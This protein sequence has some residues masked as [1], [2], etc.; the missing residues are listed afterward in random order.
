[1]PETW[2]REEK[3]VTKN[4]LSLPWRSPVTDFLQWMLCRHDGRSVHQV[5]PELMSYQT[6]IVKCNR[7]FNGQAWAQYDRAF[8]RQAAVIE[9]L[10]WSKLNPT[11]HSL[12]F[13]KRNVVLV[14]IAS[15]TCTPP[16][17][18]QSPL[19]SLSS[20]H[21]AGLLGIIFSAVDKDARTCMP[22]VQQ[23]RCH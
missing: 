13:A 19:V 10:W 20:P 6:L 7:D 11:L 12:C 17:D 9:D 14:P 3:E 8:R 5:V 22:S 18:F 16:T 15:A 2:V 4:V 23:Q 21:H 1:M